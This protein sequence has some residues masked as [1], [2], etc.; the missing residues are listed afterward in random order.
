MKG[1][2]YSSTK[3]GI[4]YDA[5]GEEPWDIS[6]F[7]K[8]FEKKDI[9]VVLFDAN[10]LSNNYSLIQNPEDIS[11]P[12]IEKLVKK[13]YLIWMN[14]IYPSGASEDVINKGLNVVSWLNSRNHITINPLTACAADYDKFYAFQLMEK[15]AVP[16]PNTEKITV[17]KSIDYFLNKFSFPLIIKRNTGGKGIGVEK[18]DDRN[19]LEQVLSEKEI[20]SGRY[21][22]QEFIHPYKNHDIRVGVIGGEPLISYGRTLVA[23]N[24][25]DMSWIGSCHHGSKIIPYQASE[26]ECKLAVLASK[27]IGANLNEVD[28]QITENGPVVIE[29]NPTPGY[30]KGEEHWVELIVDHIAESY[31]EKNV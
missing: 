20:I 24:G 7:K 4:L 21:L 19:K 27:A 18:I 22:I 2:I 1:K 9:G 5:K 12:E 10:R 28:I 3:V 6:Y 16:T 8:E 29:N 14:R 26:E 23:K 25:G 17:E 31:Q 15:Y 30:D 13:D 11:I